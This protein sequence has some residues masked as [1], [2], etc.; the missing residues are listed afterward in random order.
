[1]RTRSYLCRHVVL[2]CESE[3][4]LGLRSDLRR[5]FAVLGFL[6]TGESF[7]LSSQQITSERETYEVCDLE[8]DLSQPFDLFFELDP[9]FLR[10][11]LGTTTVSLRAFNLEVKRE[12]V[13]VGVFTLSA[14]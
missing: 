4:S 10:F 11:F 8:L 14:E 12:L 13:R 5:Q 7:E 2:V 3:A 9:R 6:H 1:M